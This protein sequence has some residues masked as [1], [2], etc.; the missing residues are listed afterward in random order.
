MAIT[1]SF[2]PSF[3]RRCCCLLN[4]FYNGVEGGSY[5]SSG[6]LVHFVF[7]VIGLESENKTKHSVNG[8][9]ISIQYGLDAKDN[10]GEDVVAR[11]TIVCEDFLSMKYGEHQSLF[12]SILPNAPYGTLSHEVGHSLGLHD[13]QDSGGLMTNPPSRLTTSEVDIIWDKA[14][15]KR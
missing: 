9:N 11:A 10:Y 1:F 7:R 13:N 15:N 8:R 12:I 4:A 14:K 6:E 3:R 2:I 5:N